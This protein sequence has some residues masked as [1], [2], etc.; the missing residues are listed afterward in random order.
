MKP[1]TVLWVGNGQDNDYQDFKAALDGSHI[2]VIEENMHTMLSE[3]AASAVADAVIVEANDT[4]QDPI[5]MCRHLRR[6]FDAPLLLV[7]TNV[8][9]NFA[10]VAYDAG[11]DEC[12]SGPIG[13]N[14]FVEKIGAHIRWVERTTR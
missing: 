10:V 12:I 14:L 4:S 7:T 5:D 11:V 2:S 3:K 6:R 8:A 9:E 13:T 1:Y